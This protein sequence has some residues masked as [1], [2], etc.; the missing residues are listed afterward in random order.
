MKA[1]TFRISCG[2]TLQYTFSEVE[3]EDQKRGG[4]IPSVDALASLR[5]ELEAALGTDLAISA[6]ELMVTATDLLGVDGVAR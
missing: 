2:F 5:A 6:I 4:L 3:L 1:Y